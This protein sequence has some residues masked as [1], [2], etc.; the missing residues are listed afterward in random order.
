MDRK[1][2]SHTASG[3][4]SQAG[5]AG[6]SR[7]S[8]GL[9]S[10]AGLGLV[11]FKKDE[12]AQVAI[13]LKHF[14][15]RYINNDT[16]KFEDQRTEAVIFGLS[17]LA[18]WGLYIASQGEKLLF[19]VIMMSVTGI[20][21]ILSWDNLF[22]DKKDFDNLS[23][24]PIKAR[25]LYMAKF[26]SMLV[27]VGSI[28]IAFSI[29][30]T[31]SFTHTNCPPV[32]EITPFHYWV[33]LVWANFLANMFVFFLIAAIRGLLMLLLRGDVHKR[34]SGLLQV[35][36]LMGFVSVLVWFPKLAEAD[37]GFQTKFTTL[38]HCFPPLWFNGLHEYL[39]FNDLGIYSL[40]YMFATVTL[41]VLFLFYLVSLPLSFRQHLKPGTGNKRGYGYLRLPAFARKGF[42]AIFLRNP[43]QEAIFYFYIRTLRRNRKQKIHLALYMALP[44]SYVVTHMVIF[45]NK[46]GAANFRIIDAGI[47]GFPFVLYFLLILGL[48]TLV[49]Q[50][51]KQEANWIFRLTEAGKAS[52]Y[53]KGL[54]KAMFFHSILPLCFSL[55]FFYL[56]FWGL[57]IAFFH[58]LYGLFTV[59]VMMEIFFLDYRKIPFTG[60]G[61]PAKLN[62]KVNW[63]LF[64]LIF[65]L[66]YFIFIKLAVLL[67]LVPP[68]NYIFYPAA[69]LI[70]IVIGWSNSRGETEL[71][72]EEKEQSFILS[73]I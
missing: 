40:H 6:R 56:Y 64:G 39:T 19:I 42:N 22:L 41:T 61:N 18:I 34:V 20:F 71:I 30:S 57:E 27:V 1:T 47:A 31:L 16:L 62:L 54:K 21:S 70:F 38:H 36:L 46:I 48:R 32:C 45:Y 68:A 3:P 2:D 59:L 7:S 43:V 65:L 11:R 49:E 17:F 44:V 52:H 14:L 15:T 24:L 10:H 66:Y 60:Q 69:A 33:T 67:I 8:L 25:T 35:V 72:F 4:D 55:F 12:V 51:V 26:S 29:L 63:P 53:I 50:P 28:S 13:L 23:L 5:P 9:A 37:P 58:S 73:L